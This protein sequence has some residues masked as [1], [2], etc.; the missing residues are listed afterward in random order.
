MQI[1]SS[2]LFPSVFSSPR[3]TDNAGQRKLVTAIVAATNCVSV[4]ERHTAAWGGEIRPIANLG[5]VA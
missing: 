5:F 2:L 3:S 1:V 4:S